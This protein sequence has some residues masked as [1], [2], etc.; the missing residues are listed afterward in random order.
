MK[1]FYEEERD[2]DFLVACERVRRSRRG[3]ASVASIAREALLQP[4]PSFYL[5]HRAARG[6][7]QEIARRGIPTLRSKSKTSL[8]EEVER[9]AAAIRAER[10]ESLSSGR[11]SR[12]LIVQPAPRFY[13][14]GKHAIAL[15][16]RLLRKQR[17]GNR[18]FRHT[19]T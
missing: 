9:R 2:E 16:Y 3:Y 12:I 10:G 18:P 19:I 7:I 17:A 8:Y 11:V 15:Y 5:S 13:I 14:S 4:A 1:L 6:I